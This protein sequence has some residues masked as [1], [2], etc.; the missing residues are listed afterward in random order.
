MD[1]QGSAHGGA[2]GGPGQA[3]GAS[4]SLLLGTSVYNPSYAA[5]P[6]NSGRALMR[7]A[8]H[9]DVDLLG[10]LLSIPLDVNLLTDGERAGGRKVTPSEV[11]LIGGVTSTFLAGPG[12]LEI[13]SR[14]E[15]DRGVDRALPAQSYIDVRARYLYSA[16][17]QWPWLARALPGGDLRGHATLGWFAYNRTYYARPDNSGLALMRYGLHGELSLWHGRASLALD[18]VV[19]TDR[20]KNPLRPSELDLTP[21]LIFRPPGAA[22]SDVEFHLAWERDMPLDSRGRMPGYGQQ[23]AYGAVAWRFRAF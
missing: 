6:D 2:V 4:G 12:A 17:R 23:F 9:A 11:D 15:H 3:I 13:G 18:A 16:A 8:G 19:F 5:R 21:E 10:L 7:Y 22:L 14:V 20:Q 1:K